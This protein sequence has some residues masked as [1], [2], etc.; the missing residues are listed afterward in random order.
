M[1]VFGVEHLELIAHFWEDSDSLNLV[2]P[3]EA[4]K[5]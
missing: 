1:Q 3:V 4:R 5:M 2:E